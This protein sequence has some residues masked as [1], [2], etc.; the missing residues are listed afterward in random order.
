MRRRRGHGPIR[1]WPRRPCGGSGSGGS[2]AVL[3]DAGDR[4]LSGWLMGGQLQDFAGWAARLIADPK[5]RFRTSKFH[6]GSA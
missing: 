5:I 3:A 4:G 6:V 2:K 1:V